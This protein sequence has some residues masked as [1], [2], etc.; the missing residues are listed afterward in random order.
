MKGALANLQLLIQFSQLPAEAF[1]FLLLF[2]LRS[3]ELQNS[4]A[5]FLK[6]LLIAF[7]G[8]PVSLLIRLCLQQLLRKLGLSQLG[9]LL[10][11]VIALQASFGGRAVI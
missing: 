3:S 8:L 6:L 1:R 4:G 7:K 11:G 9:L 5:D 10:H 2:S